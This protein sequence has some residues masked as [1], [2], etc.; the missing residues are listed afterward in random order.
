EAVAVVDRRVVGGIVIET[1]AL[2]PN[3]VEACGDRVGERPRDAARKSAQIV[4]ADRRFA[5]HFRRKPRLLADDVDQAGRGVATEQSALRPAQHFDPVD[6][7]KLVEAY[8]RARA[9]NAVDEHG[10]R[11]FEAGI[12]A[13]RADATDAR[14]AVGFR[15]GRRDQQRRRQLV[16]LADI[17][18]AAVLHFVAADSSD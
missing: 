16:Q 4:I 13:D 10:D 17:S 8:A 15:S 2:D 1:V 6:L 3:G 11:T 18:R 9:V 7:A 14:G 12:V 5:I